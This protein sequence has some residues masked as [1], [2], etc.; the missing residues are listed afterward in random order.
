MKVVYESVERHIRQAVLDADKANRR[1][2]RIE[3]SASEANEL[4]RA[5]R[6]SLYVFEP[7]WFIHYFPSDVGKVIG[8]YMGVRLEVGA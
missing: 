5:V 8:Q 2:E 1:I 7:S 4:T 3:L 6:E